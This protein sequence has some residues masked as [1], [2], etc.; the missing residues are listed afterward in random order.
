MYCDTEPV[1]VNINRTCSAIRSVSAGPPIVDDD[2]LPQRRTD[3]QR[4]NRY[5]KSVSPFFLPLRTISA[6]RQA[7]NGA[8]APDL[9][10]IAESSLTEA[11]RRQWRFRIHSS[12]NA[13]YSMIPYAAGAQ[14]PILRPQIPQ[15]QLLHLYPESERNLYG[16]GHGTSGRKSKH[17]RKNECP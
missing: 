2:G 7:V 8:E 9:S 4:R 16:T 6:A 14:F 10:T 3:P 17:R 5:R 15:A 12:S 13:G 1:T 11:C